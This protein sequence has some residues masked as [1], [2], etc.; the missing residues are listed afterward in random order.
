MFYIWLQ[1]SKINIS[2]DDVLVLT[3][4][5]GTVI[6]KKLLMPAE[7][8]RVQGPWE[9]LTDAIQQLQR[10]QS[11]DKLYPPEQAQSV[12]VVPVVPEVPV[13]SEVPSTSSAVGAEGDPISIETEPEPA[14]EPVSI[15]TDSENV[16]G[17]VE[18]ETQEEADLSV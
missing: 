13:V 3:Q 2:I 17:E 5:I 1:M 18:P 11:L 16:D 7:F 4:M 15:P 9:R 14:P 10:K 12:P 8:R 6:N